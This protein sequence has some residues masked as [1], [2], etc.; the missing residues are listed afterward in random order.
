[1]S[2]PMSTPR[3]DEA[4][5]PAVTSGVVGCAVPPARPEVVRP[6]AGEDSLGVLLSLSCAPQGTAALLCPR[7]GLPAVPGKVAGRVSKLLVGAPTEGDRMT[8]S[9]SPRR[10]HGSGE[11]GK[12]LG[13]GKR[14]LTAADLGRV[15]LGGPP[16]MPV[17]AQTVGKQVSVGSVRLV[18]CEPVALAQCPRRPARHNDHF[19][20]SLEKSVDDRSVRALEVDASGAVLVHPPAELTEP[21]RCVVDLEFVDEISLLVDDDH[22]VGVHRPVHTAEANGAILDVRLVAVGPVGWHPVVHGRFSPSLTDRRSLALSPITSRHVLGR[23]SSLHSSWR[24]SRE[25]G[26]RSTDSH[27]GCV[28][29]LTANDEGMVVQ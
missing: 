20:A 7:V 29:S 9:G 5:Q 18:A 15:R 23:R 21:G 17:G 25:R 2:S 8:P 26:W 28:A 14:R 6:G 16:T 11:T 13:V 3:F 12:R 1:M 19:Q 10:R 4:F 24:S 22:G 27:Q